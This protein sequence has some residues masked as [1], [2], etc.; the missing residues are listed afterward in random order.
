ME[1]FQLRVTGDL[2]YTGKVILKINTWRYA[3]TPYLSI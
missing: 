3:V 1:E 2:S